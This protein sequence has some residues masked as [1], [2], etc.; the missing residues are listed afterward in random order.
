MAKWKVKR[1]FTSSNANRNKSNGDNASTTINMN[2]FVHH[3]TMP[4]DGINPGHSASFGK[5]NN[6]LSSTSSNMDSY[7]SDSSR[8]LPM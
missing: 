2:S 4:F 8:Y 6:L 3:Q 1:S 5:S 7:A